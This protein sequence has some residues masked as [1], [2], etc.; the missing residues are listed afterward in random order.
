MASLSSQSLSVE[1]GSGSPAASMAAPPMRACSNSNETPVA[2]PTTS[3]TRRPSGVTS[4]PMPS[5]PRSAILCV[6]TIGSPL[7]ADL[8]L[9]GLLP[10][11][12]LDQPVERVH[13][14]TRARLDH[15]RRAALAGH[16]GAVEI[17]P[18]RDLAQSVL[19]RGDGSE[20]IVLQ[21]PLEAR[22]GVDGVE[23]GVH[24]SVADARGLEEP[25]VLF[26]PPR[27]RRDDAGAADRV[28]VVERVRLRY[29]GDLVL[30]D[31]DQVLVEDLFL[32]VGEVLEPLEGLAELRLLELEPELLQGD[33]RAARPECFPMTSLLAAR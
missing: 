23:H 5:P 6:A 12:R 19:A 1:G 26:Q 16:H 31:G 3:R 15:V 4:C 18:D 29:L 25:R 2:L 7:G 33:A 21:P 28:Q 27:G 14:G 30:D 10:D 24:G 20:L 13:V 32:L 22:D 17:H 8:F 11:G 9:F